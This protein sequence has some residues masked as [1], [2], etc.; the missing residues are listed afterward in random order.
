MAFTF[1]YVH[2]NWSLLGEPV[3]FLLSILDGFVLMAMSQTPD[4]WVAYGGFLVF[5]ALFQMMITVA[6]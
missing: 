3:L 6:R 4:I 1:G 2:L 5:R